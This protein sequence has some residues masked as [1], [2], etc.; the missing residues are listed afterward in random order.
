MGS[1]QEAIFLFVG[2]TILLRERALH[3]FER[4]TAARERLGRILE[5]GS[6]LMIIAF[7]LWMLAN[8]AI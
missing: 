6:A 3:F 7:G 5:V 2:S 8:R 1:E 4:T